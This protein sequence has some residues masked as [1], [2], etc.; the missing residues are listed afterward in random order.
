MVVKPN[1]TLVSLIKSQRFS[2]RF[3][4]MHLVEHMLE[5]FILI[6][7]N[8]WKRILNRFVDILKSKI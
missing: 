6:D 7:I 5:T 4:K 8:R 1:M 3:K 2:Q